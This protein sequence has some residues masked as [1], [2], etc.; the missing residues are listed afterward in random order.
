[1]DLLASLRSWK[2]KSWITFCVPFFVLS[3]FWGMIQGMYLS[4]SICIRF[5]SAKLEVRPT[6]EHVGRWRLGELSGR[7]TAYCIQLIKI[8]EPRADEHSAMKANTL[9]SWTSPRQR[10]LKLSHSTE[11]LRKSVFPAGR[12]AEFCEFC[13][14]S[15]SDGESYRHRKWYNGSTWIDMDTQEQEGYVEKRSENKH[16]RVILFGEFE[17]QWRTAKLKFTP[18]WTGRAA[19]LVGRG[20]S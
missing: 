8:P 12:K 6:L 2:L 15:W 16:S 13:Q 17:Q 5:F 7:H 1:M 14:G 18:M 3:I 10:N 4:E 19:A 11:M 9:P 20:H